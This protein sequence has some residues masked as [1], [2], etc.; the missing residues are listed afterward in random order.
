MHFIFN[1]FVLVSSIIFIILF[2]INLMQPFTVWEL[3]KAIISG[4]ILGII[5]G[6]VLYVFFGWK[7]V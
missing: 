6:I 7:K 3:I 4:L 2:T 1:K 5:L